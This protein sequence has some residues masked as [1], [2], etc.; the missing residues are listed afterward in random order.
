MIKTRLHTVRFNTYLPYNCIYFYSKDYHGPIDERHIMLDPRDNNKVLSLQDFPFFTQIIRGKDLNE[1]MLYKM[2]LLGLNFNPDLGKNVLSTLKDIFP[3][4]EYGCFVTRLLP[5]RDQ[6]ED[7]PHDTLFVGELTERQFRLDELRRYAIEAAQQN[8]ERMTG[9]TWDPNNPEGFFK[10]R[11][12]DDEVRS[13]ERYGGMARHINGPLFDID[14]I[15]QE[16]E[17]IKHDYKSQFE[18]FSTP[19]SFGGL[20]T[21]KDVIKKI[22]HS[23]Y[24][25]D[26]DNIDK[27]TTICPIKILPKD[28][29]Y[30][31]LFI[32]PPNREPILCD[33][34][35]GWAAKALYI[36]F[37]RH[38]EGLYLPDIENSRYVKEIAIIYQKLKRNCIPGCNENTAL[39]KAQN[40]VKKNN[41]VES[42][43]IAVI[44]TSIRK[45][46]NERF[47][48]ALAGN[49][50]IEPIDERRIAHQ[51]RLFG[52]N[53]P[54]DMIDLGS[55]GF[56]F[57]PD[58]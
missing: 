39:K 19:F 34:G 21:E 7:N 10:D 16:R 35:R 42:G 8:Y 47:V 27:I 38:P 23:G 9:L 22:I 45:W 58:L 51:S 52:I 20:N 28:D 53:I 3:D 31:D 5:Y 25:E 40:A 18:Q 50:A 56:P 4:S 30:E 36:F 26:L 2:N 49:Y 43:A 6:L 32:C 14:D 12:W 15:R 24:G 29:G 41:R 1:I 57:N 54:Q 13:L 33:F 11:N 48:L 37:L 46:F 44:M 55:F 17:R